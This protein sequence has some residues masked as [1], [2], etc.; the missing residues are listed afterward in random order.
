MN[1]EKSILSQ[2][3]ADIFLFS[4]PYIAFLDVLGFKELVFY[5]PHETLVVLYK[6]ILSNSVNFLSD[7]KPEN[8][9]D[10][11]KVNLLNIS[12]SI[13]LWTKNSNEDSFNN[14][15]NA[16]QFLLQIC[17]SLGL[18]LRGAIVKEKI[19]VLEGKNAISIIGRGLVN[20]YLEEGKQQWSG[21]TVEDNIIEYLRSYNQVVLQ[22][23]NLL[24]V[25]KLNLIV[26]TKIPLNKSFKDGYAINWAKNSSLTE[27]K[28]RNSFACY[29]K[30]K[31][32]SYCIKEKKETKILNSIEFFK[33]YSDLRI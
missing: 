16:V 6:E 14:L 28:I 25:E 13:V 9:I 26:K 8:I 3:E 18:P 15:V 4:E 11:D 2:E 7:D 20:A 1:T 22:T 24:K 33:K 30:R 32:E 23:S 21:C 27:D 29:N 17:M 12:D 5:N 19:T 10:P 31:N